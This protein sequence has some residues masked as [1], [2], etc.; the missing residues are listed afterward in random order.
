MAEKKI[1]ATVFAF[2]NPSAS[3]A[4]VYALVSLSKLEW[5]VVGRALGDAGGAAAAPAGAGV[6]LG[7]RPL[8]SQS[9]SLNT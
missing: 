6:A 3:I 5:Q 2:L 9:L 7:G 8:F 1:E 4:L